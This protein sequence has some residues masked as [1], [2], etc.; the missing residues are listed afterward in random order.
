MYT[1]FASV[2]DALMA[3]VD[4]LSWAKFYQEL[5]ENYG[6]QGGHI[7]ECACGTGNLTQYFYDFGY[8]VTASDISQE[9]LEIAYRKSRQ[10]ARDTR[11]LRFI[12]QD[13]REI[14]MH[15]KQDAILCTNDGVNYLKS[16]EDLRKFFLA[17]FQS[18]RPGGCLFFD[19]STPYKLREVLGNHFIG[20]ETG[21]ISYL[22]QNRYNAAKQY[23]EIRMA[24]FIR[25]KDEMYRRIYEEQRQY[26]HSSETIERLLGE[27]GFENVRIYADKQI[28][29]PSAQES[30]WFFSA[31]KPEVLP[32]Q[33]G[34]L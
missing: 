21:D 13:M 29:R 7:C 19:V 18:L 26:A 3:D 9:M 17:A 11:A 30:R 2:Y 6:L 14:K 22:W 20:D 23:V 34:S 10:K 12:R 16:E 31:C 8:I 28:R 5:M 27:C 15:H 4:Y 33:E 24:I 25:E 32:D 1:E